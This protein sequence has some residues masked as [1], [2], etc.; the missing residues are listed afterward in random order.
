MTLFQTYWETWIKLL[1]L[2]I[3]Q[4]FQIVGLSTMLAAS[5]SLNLFS[6]LILSIHR[7]L[8]KYKYETQE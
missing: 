1:V 7:N 4:K 3:V 6:L 5:Y 8:F 2:Q